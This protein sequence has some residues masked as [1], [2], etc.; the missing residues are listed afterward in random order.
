M[1]PDP[2]PKCTDATCPAGS[3]RCCAF[4]ERYKKCKNLWKCETMPGEPEDWSSCYIYNK[5]MKNKEKK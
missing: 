5:Y 2:G 4:C 3:D 1:K